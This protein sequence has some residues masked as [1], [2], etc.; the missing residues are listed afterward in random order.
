MRGR[1]QPANCNPGASPT[2]E[3]RPVRAGSD[4]TADALTSTQMKDLVL[5]GL[6]VAFFALAWV[7]A[8]SFD[9]L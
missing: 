2:A 9:H 5:L 3:A 8:R 4:G 6:S 1:L 7:Y